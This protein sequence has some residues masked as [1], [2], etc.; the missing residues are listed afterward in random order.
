MRL[1]LQPIAASGFTTARHYRTGEPLH[2]RWENHQLTLVTP[3]YEEACDDQWIAP[4]LFDLQVNGYAGI[5]FQNDHALSREALLHVVRTLRSDGCH[6][7][8]LTLIT[9]EWPSLLHRLRRFREIIHADP[10]LHA[11]IPGWHIEGPFISAEPGYIGAHCPE[12][13]RDANPQDIRDLK[14]L[15]GNDP[16]LLTL[17]PERSGSL[18]TIREAVRNG[19]IVSFGH[20]NATR[21]QLEAAHQA[22]A[23]AFTHLGN[24][25]PQLLD[26]HDNLLWRVLDKPRLH[27][28]IIADGIHVSPQL[29]R[30]MHRLLPDPLVWWTTDAMAAAS[31]EPGTYTI[32]KTSVTVGTDGIVRHPTTGGFAGSSLTP[33]EAI[34]RG[35]QMLDRP[36]RECWDFLSTNPAK[37]MGLTSDLQPGFPSGF[38]LLRHASVNEYTPVPCVSPIASHL[39]MARPS[40][41]SVKKP[42][43]AALME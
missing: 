14:N 37:I 22:G 1:N 40:K 24:G 6:R 25:C 11:A 26:R 12:C 3:G 20:T 21:D 5:D 35:S 10:E 43:P 31:A 27:T 19:F 18:D 16:L 42:Q 8:L 15:V 23:S 4:G 9:T 13:A 28:G 30:I 2:V 32:G 29:F 39:G 34:R 41:R 36:W 38:Q 33:I 17:A 7:F